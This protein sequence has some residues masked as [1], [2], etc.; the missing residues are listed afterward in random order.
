MTV[1][2]TAGTGA[3][4]VTITDGAGVVAVGVFNVTQPTIGIS[5]TTGY[6]GNTITVN[7]SGWVPGVLGLVTIKFNGITTAVAQPDASGTFRQVLTVPA[8]AVASNTITASDDYNAPPAATFL[9]GPA[10]ITLSPISG[11]VGTAVTVSGVGFLPLTGLGTLTI[12]AVPVLP[13][14]P[15]VTS[16]VGAFDATFTVPGLGVGAQTV[17]ATVGGVPVTVFFTITAAADTVPAQLSTI[18]TQL[19]RVW[20][21]AADGTWQRYDPAEPAATNTLAKLVPADGYFIKVTAACSITNSSGVTKSL[22]P[23][24]WIMIG[25]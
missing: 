13:A 21:T 15:V 19:V 6:R 24:V 25:W 18:S 17:T 10:V 4:T 12:G 2:V 16:N 20:G 5:S 22:T 9:L 11:P 14:T 3:Q 1:L 7:G 23:G 8:T